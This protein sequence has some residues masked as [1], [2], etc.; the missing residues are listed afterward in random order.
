MRPSPGADLAVAGRAGGDM[1]RQRVRRQ[2][3]PIDPALRA[4]A[5]GRR[6]ARGP[7]R[8]RAR[9]SVVLRG[10]RG[11]SVGCRGAP[12]GARALAQ[13]RDVGQ[14]RTKPGERASRP[15]L[16]RADREPQ[17]LGD[18]RLGEFAVVGEDEDL[19]LSGGISPSVVR[20][21]ARSQRRS[22]D[23]PGS[24]ARPAQ[25]DRPLERSSP[26]SYG[27]GAAAWTD[28]GRRC[29]GAEPIEGPVPGDPDEPAGE[30]A[31]AAGRTGPR[32]ASGE[33]HV[34][35]DLGR[36]IAVA[37]ETRMRSRT[38]GRHGGRTGS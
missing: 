38:A 7:R 20:R 1:G 11:R 10:R 37:Q 33:E 24:V 30:G 12:D 26:A 15:R 36:R 21:S 2:A 18:L 34:L 4:R 31:R 9:S 19:A 14:R 8:A 32:A 6:G 27:I 3:G 35:D 16:D 29:F 22:T 5:R 28:L 23:C 25:R 17:A 13:V